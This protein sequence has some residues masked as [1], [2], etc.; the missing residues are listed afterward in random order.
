MFRRNDP[1]LQRTLN[2]LSQNLESANETAQAG[3]YSFT[4]AYIT[5][6]LDSCGE[7]LRASTATCFPTREE[8]LRRR[9]GRMRGRAEMSFDFYDDWEAEE[10]DALLGWGNDGLDGLLS[11]TRVYGAT[12][13]QP[14]RHRTMSY[15]NR[16]RR[17][18]AE[19]Q[20]PTIIPNTSYIG[21][22]GRLPWK[23]GRRALRYRPS[24]AD[25]QENPG[26]RRSLEWEEDALLDSD[27]G[28]VQRGKM[29]P[30]RRG[31]SGTT[32]SADT[33][34]SLSSRGDLFPSEDEDDAVPIDDEF[35][36]TLD[37]RNTGLDEAGSGKSG[38]NKRRPKSTRTQSSKTSRSTQS[39]KHRSSAL[40][41]PP[42]EMS[43]EAPSI[44]DLRHE[45]QQL[46]QQE[47]SRVEKKRDAAKRLAFQ[48]GLGSPQRVQT[49]PPDATSAHAST[50]AEV[51][52]VTTPS[53]SSPVLPLP[54]ASVLSPEIKSIDE[55]DSNPPAATVDQESSKPAAEENKN[56]ARFNPARLPHFHP[57]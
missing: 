27:E 30:T 49:G 31:R 53:V 4:Q 17:P 3:L 20:D 50:P 7:C 23:L 8:R 48:R 41:S 54:A 32:C 34:D 40:S 11:G 10:N 5:P 36:L 44:T 47:E 16:N 1:R 46:E 9:R 52:Q 37:R 18:V 29:P 28:P 26:A 38:S 13:S 12:S 42:P 19:G 57:D 39:P 14:Q 55:T 43:K 25:L 33:G 51:S 35:P 45:E 56:K 2:Q 6:C 21:F 24:A 15:G 22:L